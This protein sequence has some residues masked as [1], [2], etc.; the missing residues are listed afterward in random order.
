MTWFVGRTPWSA[1]E[2]LVP[3]AFTKSV[4]ADLGVGRGLGSPP[5]P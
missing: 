4:Q 1:R 5:H 3:P 2:P